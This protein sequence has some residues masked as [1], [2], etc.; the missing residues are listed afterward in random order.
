MARQLVVENGGK[1]AVGDGKL[2]TSITTT[3][4]SSLEDYMLLNTKTSLLNS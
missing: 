4:S 2:L 3:G 1:K